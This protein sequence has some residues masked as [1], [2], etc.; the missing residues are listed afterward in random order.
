MHDRAWLVD[1]VRDVGERCAAARVLRASRVVT[2]KYD[3]A[4][5]PVGLTVTQF[6]LLNAISYL[7]PDSFALIGKSLDIDRTTLSR[8]L[9][10]LHKA[11]LVHLGEPG[12]NR[13]RE[14]LLTTR[15]AEKLEEAYPYWNEIQKEIEAIF[16][17]DEYALL[18][19]MLA[20]LRQLG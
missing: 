8:N 17:S 19:Q 1:K 20:R 15:G 18:G 7:K 2:K 4:L 3:D 11:G 14:V 10:L 12:S 6:S 5:K 9:S 16:S 13:K